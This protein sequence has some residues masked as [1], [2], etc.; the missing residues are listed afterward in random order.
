MKK[1]IETDRYGNTFAAT[2][3]DDEIILNAIE[4]L[5]KANGSTLKI[6]TMEDND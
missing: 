5:A 1:I 6:E 2:H 4:E 3:C